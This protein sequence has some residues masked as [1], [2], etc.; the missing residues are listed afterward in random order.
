[1]CQV[2]T[3]ERFQNMLK[4]SDKVD[5]VV[6]IPTLNE[7]ETIENVVSKVDI[8]LNK[9]LSSYNAVIVNVDSN[10][11]DKTKECFLRTPTRYPKEYINCNQGIIGK[12]NNLFALI[13]Y[14]LDKNAQFVCTLDGDLYS[15][16]N[17]WVY[18]LLEPLLSGKADYVT[19]LYTRN[20]YEGNTTNHFCVPLLKYAFQKN[21]RQPIGGEYAFNNKFMKHISSEYKPKYSYQY[22][23][24]MYLTGHAAGGG[25]DISEVWLGRKIHKPSFGKMLSIF[26]QEAGASY[27]ILHRYRGARV[28]GKVSSSGTRLAI[29]NKANKPDAEAIAKRKSIAHKLFGEVDEK[30]LDKYLGNQLVSEIIKQNYCVNSKL[31]VRILIQLFENT[32]TEM[33][34]LNERIIEDV[35]KLTLPLYLFRVLTYFDEIETMSTDQ[36][37]KLLAY[38]IN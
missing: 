17:N 15:I 31:W 20:R 13:K 3:L 35:S 4:T 12:G 26:E 37:E 19:P 32:E 18:K 28:M 11:K 21:I 24:D 23:I 14:A 10:S 36:I 6:G 7:E 34:K 25:F 27:Y 2:A 33:K 38:K 29:D 5:I 9:Y 30:L 22:G 1:M 16:E 8:G